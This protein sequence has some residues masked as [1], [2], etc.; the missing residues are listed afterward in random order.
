MLSDKTHVV[1]HGLKSGVAKSRSSYFASLALAGA[2]LFSFASIG[3]SQSNPSPFD[4]TGGSWTLSGWNSAVA[5]GKYPGNGATGADATTGVASTITTGNMAFHAA[6]SADPTL[7]TA[8]S[9][10]YTIAYSF[11]SKTRISGQGANGVSFVNTS[12]ANTG[13]P[14]GTLGAAVLAVNTTGRSSIQ[15]AWTGRVIASAGTFASG[16]LDSLMLQKRSNSKSHT[17]HINS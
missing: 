1:F 9:T 10:D 12:S 8:M 6:A 2:A 3:L 11:T 14:S 15:V 13:G 7:S 17:G 5:A 16:T 4:L